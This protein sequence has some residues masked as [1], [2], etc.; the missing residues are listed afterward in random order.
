MARIVHTLGFT[1]AGEC[2]DCAVNSLLT[3]LDVAE[4]KIILDNV[5]PR[6]ELEREKRP[7]EM[8]GQAIVIYGIGNG[9]NGL[10]FH[11]YDVNSPP[12]WSE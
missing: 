3:G 7:R 12:E 8:R 9:N 10:L 2:P 1:S 6:N 5:Q 11:E 4:I